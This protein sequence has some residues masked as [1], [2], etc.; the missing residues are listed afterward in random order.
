MNKKD[1]QIIVAAF[2]YKLSA[3]V[4]IIYI[5]INPQSVAEH[6]MPSI[7]LL[8]SAAAACV[9]GVLMGNFFKGKNKILAFIFY[10][11]G[12]GC[13]AMCSLAFLFDIVLDINLIQ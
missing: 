4:Q 9:A 2:C 10:F 11:H 13:L 6:T 12:I 5:F 1:V 8:C 7:I 3:W